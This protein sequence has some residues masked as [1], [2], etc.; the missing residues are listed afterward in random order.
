MSMGAWCLS[1]FGGLGTA[2]VGADL[3]GRRR[4]AQVIG[5]ANAVVGGYLGS[6]TGVLLAAT[7]VPLWARS[8][9]F[10]GPIFV[11]TAVATGAAATRLTLVAC[12]LPE[13]HHTRQA[14]GR[15]ETVAIATELVL[16]SWNERRLGDLAEDLEQGRAGVLFKFAKWSVRTG[17]AL[18]LARARV[19]TPA[20]HV[21]SV[22]YLAGGLGFRYA[23]VAAGRGSAR[24]DEAVAQVARHETAG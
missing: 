8:R 11:S 3:I 4:E 10:L 2:A 14:L 1:V 18:R 20:H 21:A 12:G 6:Y 5:G 7:A 17:L 24:D 9:L 13:G 22:L 16:S 19:G 15:V 23:W